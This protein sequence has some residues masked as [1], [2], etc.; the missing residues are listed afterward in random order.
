MGKENTGYI[1]KLPNGDYKAILEFP[2]KTWGR[3]C[4]GLSVA[5]SLRGLWVYKSD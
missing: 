3:W 1:L 4:Q 2:P 5:E